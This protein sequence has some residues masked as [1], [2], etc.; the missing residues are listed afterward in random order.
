MLNGD[1]SLVKQLQLRQKEVQGF[2]IKASDRPTLAVD[3]S[4]G[5][6]Q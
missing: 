6:L 4:F 1:R 3:H 2:Q 5:G